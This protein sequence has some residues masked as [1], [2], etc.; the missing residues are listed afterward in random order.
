ML[1]VII[2][3]LV[4]ATL[5][6]FATLVYVIADVILEAKRADAREKEQRIEINTEETMNEPIEDTVPAEEFVTIPIIDSIVPEPGDD[7]DISNTIPLDKASRERG[8][9]HG[10]MGIVNIGILCDSFEAYDVITLEQLKK[11]GLIS[12]NA[13]RLKVLSDGNL[14]KPLT[15]KAESFS[16]EAVKM[17]E[18]SGGKAIIL[19]D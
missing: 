5:L 15:V 11:K 10:K 7:S 16:V 2:I 8:A 13:G 9:G 3:F 1:V 4:I 18:C 19:I 17:I 12:K 6:A 14:N